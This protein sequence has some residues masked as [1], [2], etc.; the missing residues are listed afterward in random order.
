MQIRDAPPGQHPARVK[1]VVADT[2]WGHYEAFALNRW[3]RSRDVTAGEQDNVKST[4]QGY[5][6][7]IFLPVPKILDFQAGM[8]AGKGVGGDPNT[9]INITMVSFRYYPFQK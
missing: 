8:L 4:G 1:D 2:G 7:N 6:A 5:G 9:N 3:F